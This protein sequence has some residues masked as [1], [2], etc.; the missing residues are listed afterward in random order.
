MIKKRGWSLRLGAKGAMNFF[1]IVLYREIFIKNITYFALPISMLILVFYLKSWCMSKLQ[2]IMSF[3][4]IES[5]TNL[6]SKPSLNAN[7]TNF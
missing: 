7:Y 1:S 4:L 3:K 6:I 5:H 2:A